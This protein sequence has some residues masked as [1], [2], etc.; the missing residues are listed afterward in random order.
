MPQRS[1]HQWFSIFIWFVAAREYFTNINKRI[2]ENF[3]LNL[4]DITNDPVD[5]R[6]W[7]NDHAILK[8]KELDPY[9]GVCAT[10]NLIWYSFYG[11][12]NLATYIS[13]ACAPQIIDVFIHKNDGQRLYMNTLFCIYLLHYVFASQLRV[14]PSW[15]IQKQYT[16]FMNIFESF[17]RLVYE[18]T[19]KNASLEHFD[20]LKID[21]FARVEVFMF[22]FWH[23]KRVN[24][25]LSTTHTWEIYWRFLGTL[26]TRDDAMIKKIYATR[27][28]TIWYY[29][30]QEILDEILPQD[31]TIKYL[32]W[33][34]E[35]FEITQ[36]IVTKLYPYDEINQLMLQFLYNDDTIAACMDKI[37]NRDTL[38]QHFIEQMWLYL[39][40]K[41][42][43]EMSEEIEE[44]MSQ[45]SEWSVPPQL[46][47]ESA[48]ADKLMNFYMQAIW[49]HTIWRWDSFY[50]RYFYPELQELSMHSQSIWSAA[51]NY[52]SNK[53]ELYSISENVYT[54]L[55][56][57]TTK[58][59][60]YNSKNISYYQHPFIVTMLNQSALYTLLQDFQ[61]R[62]L[63]LHIKNTVI[64]E[65][66]ETRYRE[67][68]RH[69][70]TSS[71]HEFINH[72]FGATKEMS[73]LASQIVYTDSMRKNLKESLYSADFAVWYELT[74]RSWLIK[75]S[76][77]SV[78][79]V[80]IQIWILSTLREIYFWLLI[81]ASYLPVDQMPRLIH[82]TITYCIGIN[83]KLWDE[84]I[85][86]CID[87]CQNL[88][89]WLKERHEVDDTKYFVEIWVQ[90]R[91]EYSQK[92]ATWTHTITWNE[93]LWLQWYLQHITY[94]L[95]RSLIP[96]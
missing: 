22:L 25:L 64:L 78:F 57:K 74:I 7:L 33:R 41:M 67:L 79:P 20:I 91:L 71:S 89:P 8:A 94:Y 65:W 49:S 38:K 56:R 45:V 29:Y 34:E 48:T 86:L 60:L 23:F 31:V 39:Q 2:H 4:Y 15:S 46:Q 42:T 50:L 17:F 43:N 32:F 9:Y 6:V 18:Q 93:I 62:P 16:R 69:H 36:S 14:F 47:R 51:R 82:F 63:K 3:K 73:K 80:Q 68:I 83:T 5:I 53:L 72:I 70:A 85:A 88:T 24:T 77:R 13:M 61:P 21:L 92:I 30:D 44:Y 26:H 35:S 95:K 58:S 40:S 12:W 28:D 52:Y 27:H 10:S 84:L 55:A 54:S 66:F 11:P 90:Q 37:M 87:M 76:Y 75:N 19:H 81:V 1:S 96:L 59:I